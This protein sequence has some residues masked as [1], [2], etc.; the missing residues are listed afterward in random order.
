[1]SIEPGLS[2][3]SLKNT[4]FVSVPIATHRNRIKSANDWKT[5]RHGDAAFADYLISVSVTH[6][7]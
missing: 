1:V 6:R 3:S 2:Y 7:F 5:G 4:Y